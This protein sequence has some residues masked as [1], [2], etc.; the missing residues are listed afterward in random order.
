ML[1]RSIL[2]LVLV[3]LQ[4]DAFAIT[5][6]DAKS[7]GVQIQHAER[8]RARLAG[9]KQGL[10]LTMTLTNRG[11]HALYDVRVFLLRPDTQTEVEEPA[12]IRILPVG[13][14]AV[15]TWTYELPQSLPSVPLRNVTF[16]VEA[17]DQATQE[18]VSFTQKSM[19][20]R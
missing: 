6:V 20:A 12:R 9:R 5:P 17:V 7:Y 14:Q 18:I 8:S 3:L 4:H 1:A 11:A 16:R 2:L 15:L 19:E 10:E 13:E